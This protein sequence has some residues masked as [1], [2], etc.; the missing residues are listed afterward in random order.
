MTLAK[1]LLGGRYGKAYVRKSSEASKLKAA[2]VAYH[3][4]L[5]ARDTRAMDK[6]WTCGRDNILITRP[7]NPVTHVG[8]K[9]IKRRSVAG[10]ERG[11][12]QGGR[13]DSSG[14]RVEQ[15]C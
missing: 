14:L 2:N 4:A 10:I 3:K 13:A 7:T 1:L 12:T 5:S 9:A 11:A 6:V 8:W 15:S